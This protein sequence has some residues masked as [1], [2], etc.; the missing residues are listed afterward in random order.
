M[1]HTVRVWDLPTRLFHWALVACIVGSAVTGQVGGNA[2]VWHFRCGYAIATLLL[3][4]ILWGFV[5]GRWSRFASFVKGPGAVLAYLRGRAPV[6]H[7]AGHNPLGALSVIA[8]LLVLVA[9]VASGSMSDDEIAWF[10]PMTKFV[11]GATVALATW[12]HKGWGKYL[13]LALV[14]LHLL[15]VAYYE[16]VKRQSIVGP[17]VAGDKQFA[18]PVASARD[19]LASRLGALVLLGLCAGVVYWAVSLGA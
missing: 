15:A 16:A 14:L 5:G 7:T 9:Q 12:Y 4:R 18:E 1:Q 10:G 13:V 3:F 8:M 11:S 6:L 2:M 17:M 19:D